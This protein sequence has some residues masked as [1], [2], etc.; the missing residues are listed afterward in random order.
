M[1]YAIRFPWISNTSYSTWYKLFEMS[2]ILASF[3][4][5]LMCSHVANTLYS[6]K[7]VITNSTCSLNDLTYCLRLSVR[8]MSSSNQLWPIL[9]SSIICFDVV[10][11]PFHIEIIMRICVNISV[12]YYKAIFDSIFMS[13][14]NSRKLLSLTWFYNISMLP[15]RQSS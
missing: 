13:K 7:I 3:H 8:L 1:R 15:R 11:K 14:S 6:I 10:F 12:Q 2:S 9:H 5:L 4:A